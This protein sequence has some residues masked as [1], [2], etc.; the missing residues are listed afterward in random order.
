MRFWSAVLFLPIVALCADVQRVVVLKLDGVPASFVERYAAETDPRTG[1]S[2]LPWIKHLFF[3]NGS[4]L[5]NFYAR[6]LS[7]SAP[8]WAIL[9]TGR[10]SIIKGNAEFD[11]YTMRTYDY[12]HFFFLLLQ[13]RTFPAS[14]HS[15][16]RSA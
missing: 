1:K 10:H 15:R 12:L 9:D 5:S 14:G 3:D 11:R 16:R 4:R 6:G 8:A 7:L 2:Q 13:L